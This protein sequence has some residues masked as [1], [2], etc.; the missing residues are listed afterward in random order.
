MAL[1][2][3][4]TGENSGNAAALILRAGILVA[5][6][7]GI[8][9]SMIYVVVLQVITVPQLFQSIAKAVLGKA[10]MEGGMT[11]AA[12]GLGM[13]I[14]VALTWSAVYLLAWRRWPALR[15][16]RSRYGA[17]AVGLFYGPFVWVMMNFVVVP[18]THN[19]VSSPLAG[20][21]WVM[22][23]GHVAS[24]GIPIAVTIHPGVSD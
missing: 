1:P 4:S 16:F 24:V 8:L 15:R 3:A 14:G 11:T 12:I 23:L 21:F 19:K 7:D 13:H 18:F 17:V 20:M 10:A 22:L 5:V 6:L 2:A 9:A